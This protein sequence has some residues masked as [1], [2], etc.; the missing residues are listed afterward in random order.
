[1]I[2]FNFLWHEN[3]ILLYRVLCLAYGF[4]STLLSKNMQKNPNWIMRQTG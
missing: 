1:M 4:Q 3:C 2:Q